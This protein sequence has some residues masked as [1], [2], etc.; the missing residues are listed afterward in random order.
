MIDGEDLLI[1]LMGILCIIMGVLL[2]FLYQAPYVHNILFGNM[3]ENESYCLNNTDINIATNCLRRELSSF[4]NY[5]LS[6]Q[7]KTLSLDELKAEGGVC[8]HYAEWY[9][10]NALAL[11]FDAKA[12]LIKMGDKYHKVAILSDKDTYCIADQMYVVCN[13]LDV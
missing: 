6:N 2:T 9:R 8:W 4:Y 5:N 13:D 10:D 1:F 7:N 3:E 11:G 12:V